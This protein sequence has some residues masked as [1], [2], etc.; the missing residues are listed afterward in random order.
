MYQ[1]YLQSKFFTNEFSLV[2]KKSSLEL[3]FCPWPCLLFP[4]N[5]PLTQPTEGE[6]V[7]TSYLLKSHTP[8]RTSACPPCSVL[9]HGLLGH[10]TTCS[11]EIN[12]NPK[13]CFMSFCSQNMN[14]RLA[15]LQVVVYLNVKH[16][17]CRNSHP[18]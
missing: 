13:I 1:H 14:L 2:T 7:S 16:C 4:V 6:V 3:T 17:L 18:G 5:E 15:L 9:S 11:R 8:P 10:P 12:S